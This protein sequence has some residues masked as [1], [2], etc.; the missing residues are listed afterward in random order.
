ML[1]GILREKHFNW[2]LPSLL[3]IT[4]SRIGVEECM[5]GQEKWFM[6]MYKSKEYGESK[7]YGD[8]IKTVSM[9]SSM[10]GCYYILIPSSEDLEPNLKAM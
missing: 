4:K 2:N 10:N 5:T 7:E 6:Y 9:V 1:A 8:I 3:D